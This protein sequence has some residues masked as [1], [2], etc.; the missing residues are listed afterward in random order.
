VAA[1]GASG[2]GRLGH[3]SFDDEDE[4]D[5]VPPEDEPLGVGDD[6][7]DLAV[8]AVEGLRPISSPWTQA[9]T[10]HTEPTCLR[11]ATPITA[12]DAAVRTL[13]RWMSEVRT[14]SS[15]A[16]YLAIGLAALVAV[17]VVAMVLG[18]RPGGTVTLTPLAAISFGMVA[19]GIAFG[20]NRAVGYTFFALGIGLAIVD[21]VRKR[22]Q[23]GPGEGGRAGRRG[24]RGID[25]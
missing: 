6:R 17:A 9:A 16:F 14:M 22:S 12:P 13:V 7:D 11:R 21:T 24:S 23:R 2:R 5:P 10:D 15:S 3:Q 25:A 8:E 20:E 1:A 4:V 19:A 18:R